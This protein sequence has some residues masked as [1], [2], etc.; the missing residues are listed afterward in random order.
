VFVAH[1]NAGRE[2]A[3]HL[4]TGRGVYLYVIDGDAEVLGE[5][6]ATGDAAQITDTDTISIRAHA[7]AELILV[8]VSL[9]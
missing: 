6:L 4:G 7:T 8:D 5:R 1:V 3:H 2:V 9:A